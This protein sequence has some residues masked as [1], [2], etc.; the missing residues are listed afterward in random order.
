[1]PWKTTKAPLRA[2]RADG[3]WVELEDTDGV[4]DRITR[5][6]ALERAQALIDIRD[7]LPAAKVK[8]AKSERMGAQDLIEAFVVAA[9]EARMNDIGEP[10]E[11][12]WVRAVIA[13][14]NSR[15]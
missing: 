7:K 5:R 3:P 13:G 2:I 9:N 1:M 6:M 12:E 4:K 14:R 11:S 10:Y 15:N 8:K